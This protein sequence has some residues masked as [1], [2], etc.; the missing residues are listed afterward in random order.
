MTTSV[1]DALIKDGR[2]MSKKRLDGDFGSGSNKAASS[3]KKYEPLKILGEGSFGKVSTYPFC[4]SI[5]YQVYDLNVADHL[6]TTMQV[7]LMKHVVKRRLV[8]VKVIKI[9]KV[10]R[11]EREACCQEVELMQRLCHPNIVGYVEQHLDSRLS[12]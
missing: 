1:H 11:K 12:I 7:Y 3:M 5:S 10:P 4:R 8:C 6:S 9:N 2:E